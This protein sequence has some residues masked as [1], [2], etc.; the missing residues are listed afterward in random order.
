MTKPNSL[1]SGE[2]GIY[3]HEDLRSPIYDAGTWIQR[4]TSCHQTQVDS[5][6]SWLYFPWLD[7]IFTAGVSLLELAAINLCMFLSNLS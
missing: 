3:W 1:A 5:P 6:I 7:I 4:P 2:K